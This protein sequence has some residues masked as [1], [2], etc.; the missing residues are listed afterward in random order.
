M[1]LTNVSVKNFRSYV[2]GQNERVPT[3]PIGDGLNLLVGPNNC[4][5]SNLLRAVALAL[6]GKGA[7]AFDPDNDLPAQLNWAYPTVTLAFKCDP[8]ISVD[9]TLLR[10]AK[11]YELSANAKVAFAED[12]IIVLRVSYTG[13]GRDDV[14]LARGTGNRRGDAKK[15]ARALKQVSKCIRFIYLRSGESL[16]DFLVGAFRELLHTVIRDHLK[17]HVERVNKRRDEY[18]DGVAQELLHPL[19]SHTLAQLREV[20]SELTGLAIKPYVPKLVETLGKADFLLTDTAETTLLNKGTGVRGALLVGLLSYLA[21]HPRRS[22]ILAVEEPETF[23]HPQ[24]QQELREDLVHLAERDDVT[25]LVTTHSPFLL[26]RSPTTILTPF[27][28]GP[29]GRTEIGEQVKGDQSLISV[30]SNLFGETITPTVLEHI[31]PLRSNATAVLFVEGPTDKLYFELAASACGQQNLLNGLDIRYGCGADKAALQALLL[32]QMAQDA[33]P[34]GVLLD[35]DEPGKNAKDLLT[36][37][38]NWRGNLAW[39]Y[40]EWR[41]DKNTNVWVEAE[42]MFAPTLLEE[43]LETIGEKALAEKMQFNDGSFHYGLTHDAKKWFEEFLVSN[44][45]QEHCD[46]WILILQ[47]LRTR[48]GLDKSPSKDGA[49]F[50]FVIRGQ[51]PSGATE[52]KDERKAK[53]TVAA[54]YQG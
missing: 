47:D 5:K 42:D 23:L 2:V 30:A 15:M 48:L 25:L 27:K 44:L 39:T 45:K 28:R 3:V 18:I 37:R 41:K 49:Q 4:G 10:F 20:M 36:K 26:D 29:D 11:D 24:A 40:R 21:Q 34:I 17:E 9:R 51:S 46:K 19:A 43:F 7:D 35:W 1:K 8:R 6:H 33:Y 54:P 32:K 38:Y 22:L 53:V 16:G 31:Q 14:L 12:G 52:A 13:A 50:G